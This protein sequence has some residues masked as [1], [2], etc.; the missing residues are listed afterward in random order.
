M[1][2]SSPNKNS[3]GKIS[4]FAAAAASAAFLSAVFWPA[5]SWPCPPL[6]V[7]LRLTQGIMTP[8]P[9]PKMTQGGNDPLTPLYRLST[10]SLSGVVRWWHSN[11]YFSLFFFDFH[12]TNFSR[13][14]RTFHQFRSFGFAIFATPSLGNQRSFFYPAASRRRDQRK[15]PR[16]LGRGQFSQRE[17]YSLRLHDHPGQFAAAKCPQKALPPVAGIPHTA[18]PGLDAST[19]PMSPCSL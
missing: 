2:G 7:T 6:H 18:T 11:A 17:V 8:T 16:G 9:P 1:N 14:R 10:A 4:G 12:R 19:T 3:S 15:R 13:F 5:A